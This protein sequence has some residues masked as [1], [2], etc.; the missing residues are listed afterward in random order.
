MSR[1]FAASHCM[2]R[3]QGRFGLGVP[4]EGEHI[5]HR[6]GRRESMVV[7]QTPDQ[8]LP[9]H[10][11]AAGLELVFD[12]VDDKTARRVEPAGLILPRHAQRG[13]ETRGRFGSVGVLLKKAAKNSPDGLGGE[14]AR[15]GAVLERK[16][17]IRVHV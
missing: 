8:L 15:E 10:L 17:R 6:Q 1:S 12:D 4:N 7:T 16:A 2:A 5:D 11:A 3:P 13:T 14:G 9:R